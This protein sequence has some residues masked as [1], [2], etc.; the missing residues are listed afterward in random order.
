MYV[1]SVEYMSALYGSFGEPKL[2]GCFIKAIADIDMGR[3]VRI[4]QKTH[5]GIILFYDLAR[6]YSVFVKNTNGDV[7][8]LRIGES[9]NALRRLYL[10][11]LYPPIYLDVFAAAYSNQKQ[12]ERQ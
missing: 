2:F 9:R 4:I 6:N 11:F 1:Y 10:C 3:F 7:A 8:F 5:K 12:N